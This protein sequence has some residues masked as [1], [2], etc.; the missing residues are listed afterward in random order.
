MFS[1]DDRDALVEAINRYLCEETTA[2]E[3]DKVISEIGARTKDQTV[4][5]VVALFWYHYDD[6]DDHKIV[7]AKEEWDFFHR[8]LLILKSDADIVAEPGKRMWT[9]RQAASA[10]CLA[11]FG[12]VIVE[13]GFGRHLY[14]ATVPLGIISM[15]LAH[16]RS[17]DEGHRFQEQAALM[18]FNSVSALLSL[19][20]K[21]RNFVKVRYPIRLGSRQ[22]RS[23]MSA[24]AM[25]LHFGAVWLL[26]SPMA[27]ILQLLPES[28]HRW[29]VTNPQ[30]GTPCRQ[31]T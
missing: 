28:E 23:P 21:V 2:F 16:W 3:L 6:V 14:C 25:W 8:L 26:F 29:K 15:L 17:C 10:V 9:L 20:R 4:K 11:L 27:L 22:I 18:P 31:M 19:R 7:A 30:S 12:L 13:T 5:H 24:A 1:R